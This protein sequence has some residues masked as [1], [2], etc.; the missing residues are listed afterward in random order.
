MSSKSLSI[1][2]P[3]IAVALCTGCSEKPV[4]EQQ[5]SQDGI[6]APVSSITSNQKTPAMD[7][8][9]QFLDGLRRGG[10][11]SQ[12]LNLVTNKG[13]EEIRRSGLVMEPIGSPDA[14]FNV[15][16]SQPLPNDENSALVHS[17]WTEPSEDGTEQETEIVWSVQLEE[18]QWK[19]SGMVFGSGK[20][21]RMNVVD[22]ENGDA[23]MARMPKPETEAVERQAIVPTDAGVPAN[24]RPSVLR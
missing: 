21:G 6:V 1:A 9:S 8:V 19:I 17:V 3:L 20:G 22:F 10:S 11:D 5:P 23:L 18:G 15:T 13:Q 14:K 16:R 12:T 7:V 2:I 4:A 24:T